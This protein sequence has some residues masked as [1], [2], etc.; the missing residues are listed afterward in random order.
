MKPPPNIQH[1]SGIPFIT[2]IDFARYCNIAPSLIHRGI[3]EVVAIDPSYMT[4]PPPGPPGGYPHFWHYNDWYDLSLN[5][6]VRDATFYISYLGLQVIPSRVGP[7]KAL[8]NISKK[9][10]ETLIAFQRKFQDLGLSYPNIPAIKA[11]DT[12]SKIQ[13]LIYWGRTPPTATGSAQR[14]QPHVE[15]DPAGHSQ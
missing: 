8:R 10:V 9:R 7:D 1:H 6:R 14:S 5:M 3:R 13:T 2:S 4:P 11:T 12:A 15:P